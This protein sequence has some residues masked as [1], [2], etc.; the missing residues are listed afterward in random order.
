[1][2]DQPESEA[3]AVDKMSSYMRG[4]KHTGTCKR[5]NFNCRNWICTE[6]CGLDAARAALKELKAELNAAQAEV[7]ELKA[8]RNS[9]GHEIIFDQAAE[10]TRLRAENE[11]LKAKLAQG[12]E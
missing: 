6:D 11:A 1:M 2:T 8:N 4:S 5:A 12:G 10:I 7:E 9:Q 3:G